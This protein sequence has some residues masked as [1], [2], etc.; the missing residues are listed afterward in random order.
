[1]FVCYSRAA[2]FSGLRSCWPLLGN[3][4]NIGLWSRWVRDMFARGNAN[5][6]GCHLGDYNKE[7]RWGREGQQCTCVF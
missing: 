4:H 3:N 7:T 5:G 6:M 2:L 1:M